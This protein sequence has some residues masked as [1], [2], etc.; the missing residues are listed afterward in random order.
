MLVTA[1]SRYRESRTLVRRLCRLPGQDAGE[2]KRNVARLREHF[3]RF[4]VDASELCQ[5]WMGLR[6]RRGNAQNPASF[7][8]LGDFLLQPG[9]QRAEADEAQRDRW[10]ALVFDDVAGFH[11]AST[12]GPHA[13][14][15]ALR[16]AM[17]AESAALPQLRHR[18]STLSK[19]FERLERLD[20]AHRLVLLKS[21]AEWIVARYVRGVENWVRQRAEWEKEK[22]DWEAAHPDLTPQIRERFTAVF[23]QLGDDE[24]NGR[25]GLRRKNPRICSY[26]RLRQNLDNCCYAGQKGHGPLCWRYAEFIKARKERNSHFNPKRFA[27]DAQSYL[28]HRRNGLAPHEAR[29]RIFPRSQRDAQRAQQRFQENWTAY[30]GFSRPGVP[31]G[32]QG[33]GPL[34]EETAVAAGCLPHCLKIGGKVWEKSECRWNPH[35]DLCLQYKRALS[36]PANGFDEATLKLESLYRQWRALYLA[37]PRKPSFRYPSSRDLPMP[38]IFGDRYH[39][40]DMERSV[41]RLRLDDMREGE[42]IEFG[43]TPWPRGYRPSKRDV[44]VT[45]VHVNFVG[46]RLRVG[47]RFDA[48]H[49][50]SRFACSQD[51]LDELRSRSFP[52]QA[53]DQEFLNAARQRLLESFGGNAERDLRLLAVDLGMTGAH[54]ALY[55]G[56]DFQSHS[57]LPIVKVNKAYCEVPKQ[58]VH[59]SRMRGPLEFGKDDPRGVRKE[60]VGRHL[61][62]IA[63]GAAKI[64]QVRRR[65]ER[66]VPTLQN[67]DLRGPKRHIA[68][69]VRDWAR[70]NAARIIAEAEKNE[71]DLIVFESLRGVR[72]PG[73]DELSD[74]SRRKKAEGVLY[75]YGRLRAKVREKAVERGMRVVTVP[76]FKSSQVCSQCGRVQENTGLWRKHKRERKFVCE[77]KKCG[78]QLDSDANAARVL[79]RVFWDEITLPGPDSG[80]PARR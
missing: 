20:P 80:Q 75:A 52:R 2:F 53:Q 3:Q 48:P 50:P 77:H 57:P 23:K 15:P 18:N 32:A 66:A 54:V 24:R 17:Y 1:Q 30:L 55:R 6:K 71:C 8:V 56:R 76:Y 19:L 13:I 35:T 60:H 40:V 74:D 46:T 58:L 39:E 10:R 12:L 28:S 64:A 38:K 14:P 37:G 44:R 34:S 45:S 31:G 16:E 78:A 4:N 29:Q 42:W 73:Y 7:G 47:F 11:P 59:D 43:F 70:H 21:A 65:D 61:K 5:W 27:D 69:M 79:A 49:K 72:L 68:W 33:F 36:N 25:I 67:H 22:L 62:R 41:L 26:E 63:E 51:E 9:I